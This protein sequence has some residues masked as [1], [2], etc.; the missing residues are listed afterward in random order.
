MRDDGSFIGRLDRMTFSDT[1]Y[2]SL[3]LPVVVAE[4]LQW[5]PVVVAVAA[6]RLFQTTIRVTI[7]C[8]TIRCVV[9]IIGLFCRTSSLL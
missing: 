2:D 1:C 3:W 5:L 4:L 7:R 8:V 9:E 6:S